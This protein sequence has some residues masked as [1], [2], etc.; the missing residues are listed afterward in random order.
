[1]GSADEGRGCVLGA[2]LVVALCAAATGFMLGV[3]VRLAVQ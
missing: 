1:M 2:I 3:F